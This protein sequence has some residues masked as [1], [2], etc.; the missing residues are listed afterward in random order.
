MSHKKENKARPEI[1]VLIT[2]EAQKEFNGLPV[3]IKFRVQEIFERLRNWPDVSG[4]KGLGKEL[5][6]Q[7]RIRTG[8][9]RLQFR[10][11]QS[12]EDEKEVTVVT[13]VKVGHR[14]GFY[15]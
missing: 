12:K 15:E 1:R 11:D 4:A 2:R 10:L 5:A 3:E 9:Y 8:K 13:I 7:Y 14:E 6:G